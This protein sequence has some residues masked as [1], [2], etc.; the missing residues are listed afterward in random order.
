MTNVDLLNRNSTVSVVALVAPL[1]VVPVYIL[2]CAS[3]VHL[4]L[5]SLESVI[6]QGS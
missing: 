2:L 4:D 1:S 3:G 5:D 6:P